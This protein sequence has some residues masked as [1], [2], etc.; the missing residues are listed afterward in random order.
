[1]ADKNIFIVGGSSGIGLALVKVLKNTTCDIYVGSRSGGALAEFPGVH[2]FTLDATSE[3]LDLEILPKTLQ[4]LVYCP[5]TIVLKPFQRLTVED[6]LEDLQINLLGAVRVIKGSLSRLKKSSAG[7]SI[8]L[9]ST[10]AVKAGMAFHASVS[11]AKGAVEGLTRALAAEFAPRIRVNAIAPS[12]TDTPLARDLLSND[13][14]RQISAQR[15]P[16]QRIGKTQDIAQLAAHLL[17]DSGAWITGQIIHVDGGMS[18][19]R[20]FRQ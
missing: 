9:F 14:K 11:S 15:H 20:V 2:H 5:G 17:S 7:A 3:A 16:L 6:F 10:V 18:S 1:M 12:L 4:G 8:V 13:E 19:L